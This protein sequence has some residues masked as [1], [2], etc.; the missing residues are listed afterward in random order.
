MSRS[1]VRPAARPT[2]VDGTTRSGTTPRV[3]ARSQRLRAA[4]TGLT[5]LAVAAAAAL[6]AATPATAHD[7]LLESDPADGATLATP[8]ERIVL[9]FNNPVLQVS[10][11]IAVTDPDGTAVGD[12]AA[13]VDGANVSI[14]LPVD[15]PAGT[16]DVQWRVVSSDGHPIEGELSYDVEQSAAPEPTTE[17]TEPEP[18]P[19]DPAPTAEPEPEEPTD[20][21]PTT[22]P[23]ET[24]DPETAEPGPADPDA[25]DAGFPSALAVTLALVM[26]VATGA[27]A[28]WLRRRSGRGDQPG[29][30]QTGTDEPGGPS[31]GPGA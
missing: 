20:P 1:A 5:G 15:V 19:T 9:T 14:D 22:D 11:T 18:E 29:T 24:A 30:D 17:P 28:W 2:R 3:R 21:E 4:L 27:V 13:V 23:E 10:P 31:P 26:L 25:D 6:G 7:V 12:S 8:P 16:Y